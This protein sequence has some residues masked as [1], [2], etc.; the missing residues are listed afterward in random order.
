[1]TLPKNVAELYQLSPMQH[2]MLLH[3]IAQD[4]HG[5]L[6]NQVSYD[7]RGT[8]DVDAFRW[9]WESLVARHAALRTVF[10]WEGLPHPV[11]VVRTTVSLDFQII[12]LSAL[13][14]QERAV[15]LASLT[16]AD[17][18]RPM[19]LGKAPLMRCTVIRIGSTQHRFLWTVH[20][21]VVDRWSHAI[22]FEELRA[23]YTVR[24]SGAP[25]TGAP[26]TLAPA[27]RFQPYVEW[28]AQQELAGGERFW[29]AELDGFEAPTPL[30]TG[31]RQAGGGPRAVTV[32]AVTQE[33]T[34]AIR[35]VASRLRVTPGAVLQSAVAL[36][37]AQRT[38]RDDV[39]YGL[40]VS[41]RPPDLLD[42]A[43][44]VGSFV[45]NVPSR[46][47]LDPA[48]TIE[49]LVRGVHHGEGRRAQYM[50][51]SPVQLHEW[52]ALPAGRALFDTLVLL[53]LTNDVLVEWP[54]LTIASDA[55]T[56]DAS[57][58]FVLAVGLEG[59]VYTL[60]LVHDSGVADAG[61]TLDALHALLAR[62][63]SSG[64]DATVGDLL[65][66]FVSR[67]RDSSAPD[68][69]PDSVPLGAGAVVGA[70]A[71]AGGTVGAP[72]ADAL[73]G[74]WRD[75]LAVDHLGL[76]DDFFAVGGTSMQAA[77]LFAR[78]E[79]IAGR[80]M[81]LS[82]LFGAGSVRAMLAELDRPIARSGAL[83]R[84]RSSGTRPT[85]YAI[86]G[87][88]GNVVSLSG[89]ARHMGPDQPFSAFES[90]GLDGGEPPLTS[91]EAIAARY[92][93]ELVRAETGEIHLVGICWG[94]A[95]AFEMARQLRAL[96]RPPA[97]L[98]LMDPA[99]LLRESSTQPPRAESGFVRERLELYWD[100]FRAGSW[101]DRSRLLAN[102]ARRAARALAGSDLGPQSQSERNL[103]RVREANVVAVTRYIPQPGEGAARLFLTVDRDVGDGADP[104]L[105]WLTLIAPVP[106]VV[107]I[108][109]INSGDAISPAHVGGFARALQ[110]WLHAPDGAAPGG[111]VTL[112]ER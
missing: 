39:V 29:R 109:G 11:Q 60:N 12:D 107:T 62:L 32:R 59:D 24:K 9:A 25:V 70:A 40:T 105:E 96:G 10:L 37:L 85:L 42:V 53:N 112:T 91:I 8:L 51:L 84:V 68:G 79:R 108:G 36:L 110:A 50:H 61:A 76:D 15:T 16:D 82:T 20:H 7:M 81:P 69:T 90:P 49:A 46:V 95:V 103:F 87:I 80:T 99:V 72:L 26:V 92:V 48:Q 65:P 21:L 88:G 28:I 100:E 31:Q 77:Q 58:P 17:A 41:G 45:N 64:G 33:V 27:P 89:L 86:P 66:N 75:I 63:S 43:T 106:S 73:L 93:D 83:V 3:A 97:T 2:L 47:R 67:P 44:T 35:R 74:A 4:G 5:V 55:A 57:Y 23:L 102:K 56:L 38:G 34:A 6:L 14:P 18:R 111:S 1:M 78:I 19:A 13:S 101:R 94:A 104:R 30:G 71:L 52:S 98:A 22:L 54:D